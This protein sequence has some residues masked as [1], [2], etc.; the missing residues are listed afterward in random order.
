MYSSHIGDK[1][2]R[3]ER[4]PLSSV[5]ARE[6]R[7]YGA[8]LERAAGTNREPEEVIARDCVMRERRVTRWWVGRVVWVMRVL[9]EE[10][11]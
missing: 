6:I 4:P 1:V 11:V 9:W 5:F 10:Q 2:P 7:S 3:A 8:H